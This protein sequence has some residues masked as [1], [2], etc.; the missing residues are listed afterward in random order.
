MLYPKEYHSCSVCY[1]Q[2]H[3]VNEQRK[4]YGVDPA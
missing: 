1:H 3:L 4:S 2:K